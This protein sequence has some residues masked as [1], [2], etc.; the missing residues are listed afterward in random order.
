MFI[1][2]RHDRHPSLSRYPHSWTC[3]WRSAYN[4]VLLSSH[5]RP[6][7]V[8]LLVRRSSTVKYTIRRGVPMAPHCSSQTL[9]CYGLLQSLLISLKSEFKLLLP[10]INGIVILCFSQSLCKLCLASQYFHIWSQRHCLK[11]II[12]IWAQNAVSVVVQSLIC[13][14]V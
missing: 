10:K 1:W 13:I 6:T 12:T 2:T 5:S 4:I 8:Q 14:F 11:E 7:S 3:S 9:W